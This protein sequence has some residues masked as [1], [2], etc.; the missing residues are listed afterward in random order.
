MVDRYATAS[1]STAVSSVAWL[2]RVLQMLTHREVAAIANGL[3]AYFPHLSKS[4]GS[5]I[6]PVIATYYIFFTCQ[7]H[8]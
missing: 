8:S 3:S 6:V 2:E 5:G 1:A 7:L 4:A